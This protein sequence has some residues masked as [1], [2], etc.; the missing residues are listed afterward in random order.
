MCRGEKANVYF[1]QSSFIIKEINPFTN[2]VYD[3][4]WVYV[5]I[6]NEDKYQILDKTDNN[7]FQVYISRNNSDWKWRLMD[8][9]GYEL[10]YNKNIIVNIDSDEYQ[11]IEQE[12]IGH[13]YMDSNL[14]EYENQVLVHST[15]KVNYKNIEKTGMLKS[16]NQLKKNK[17]TN[18]IVPI[19]ALL[20]DHEE[21]RDY[22]MFSDGGVS[23]EIVVNSKNYGK[24]V[25]DIDAEYIPGARLYF[26]AKRMAESGLLVRD[27]LH[28]KVKDELPLKDYLLWAATVDN[29]ELDDKICSPSNF[30][31]AADCK[32][33]KLYGNMK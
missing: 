8:F 29:V 3:K 1:V 21:Y 22:I 14:R 30:T 32:F 12:Y 17:E 11:S 2:D 20:G 7:I 5:E 23:G 4:N 27:G 9:V 28:Y 26:D 6:N 19:G 33:N 31:S 24:I 10:D 13:S 15:T 18:E 25:M 16:W